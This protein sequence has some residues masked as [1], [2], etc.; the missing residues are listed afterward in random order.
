MEIAP[1]LNIV[2]G[3]TAI[4]GSGGKTT[5]LYTLAEE[6]KEKGSVIICTTT[7]IR[8][9]ERYNTRDPG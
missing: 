2:R 9:P 1:L 8:I 7:H 4:I 3:V 5:L 6:L